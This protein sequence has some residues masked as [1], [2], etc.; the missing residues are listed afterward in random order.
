M[1]IALAPCSVIV[2]VGE[3]ICV[4]NTLVEPLPVM[5]KAAIPSP[6]KRSGG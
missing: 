3:D 5:L 4:N 2:F 1:L 6:V